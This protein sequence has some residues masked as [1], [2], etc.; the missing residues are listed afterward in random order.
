M[1]SSLW[2]LVLIVDLFGCLFLGFMC[3]LKVMLL[4]IVMWWNSV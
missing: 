2:I 3:R 4:N 1:L